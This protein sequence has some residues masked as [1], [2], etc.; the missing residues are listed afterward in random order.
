MKSVKEQALVATAFRK[1]IAETRIERLIDGDRSV[2]ALTRHF[3]ALPWDTKVFTVTG[4]DLDQWTVDVEKDG[5]TLTAIDSEG[6]RRLTIA[7]GNFWSHLVTAF[8][9]AHPGLHLSHDESL[10]E[11]LLHDHSPRQPADLVHRRED[12]ALR[13]FR[14]RQREAERRREEQWRTQRATEHQTQYAIWYQ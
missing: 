13:A 11:R 8:E 4:R 9:D 10:V 7:G 12:E 6:G 1:L 3:Q 2:T 5:P 14:L